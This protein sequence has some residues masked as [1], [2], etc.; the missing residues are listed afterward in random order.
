[1][2]HQDRKK[3]DYENRFDQHESPSIKAQKSVKIAKKIEKSLDI[4]IETYSIRP[5]ENDHGLRRAIFRAHSR[6]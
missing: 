3:A 4:M 6:P 5:A 1:M 2:L